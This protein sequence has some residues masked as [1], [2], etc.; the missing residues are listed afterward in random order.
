MK[1]KQ[2]LKENRI[3]ATDFA[4]HLNTTRQHLNGILNGK[5]KPALLL[6]EIISKST[7]QK[8]KIV[9]FL[10]GSDI[11]KITNTRAYKL[12]KKP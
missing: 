9:D 2:Y 5:H 11:K 4:T 1:L 6:M 3:K 10:K 7:K 12:N 8:V